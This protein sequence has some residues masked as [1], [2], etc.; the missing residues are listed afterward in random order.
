M[1]GVKSEGSKFVITKHGYQ[2]SIN[3]LIMDNKYFTYDGEYRITNYKDDCGSK[4]YYIFDTIKSAQNEILKLIEKDKA[5]LEIARLEH[6]QRQR[7]CEDRFRNLMRSSFL[8][9]LF[10]AGAI[11]GGSLFAWLF[12]Q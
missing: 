2:V 7:I 10:F 4:E 5:S 6:Q 9:M 8:I 11:L 12:N 3:G 1:Y